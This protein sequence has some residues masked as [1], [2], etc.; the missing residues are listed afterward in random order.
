MAQYIIRD[1][2]GR[3]ERILND[4]EYAEHQKVGCISKLFLL[5]IS[6][7]I[8]V[9]VIVYA[10]KEEKKSGSVKIEKADPN[11]AATS[12]PVLER[13]ELPS[14]NLEENEEPESM[15]SED[16]VEQDRHLSRKEKRA[17]QRA[18]KRLEKEKR[19]KED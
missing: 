5:I 9:L 16:E 8:T 10:E 11:P 13:D 17:L 12:D 3:A 7:I 1:S 2:K 18:K 15:V 4:K 19:M 14:S 6:A